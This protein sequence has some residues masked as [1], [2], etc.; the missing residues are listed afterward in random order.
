MR[1]LCLV[2]T[3]PALFDAMT[4]EEDREMT[5]ASMAYD[6]SLEASGHYVLAEALDPPPTA[7]TIKNR[8]GKITMTDGPYAE[9]KEH[10]GGFI[11]IEARDIEEATEIGSKIPMTRMGSIE[12][13]PIHV[14]A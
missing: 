12:V 2:Y 4:P 5:R 11:L 3:D 8:A 1:F 9:T 7:R 14:W 6:K 13:R 10:L